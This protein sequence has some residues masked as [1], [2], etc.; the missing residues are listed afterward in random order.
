LTAACL[1]Y[2]VRALFSDSD[3]LLDV[4]EM[5]QTSPRC[6]FFKALSV[7]KNVYGAA[8]KK[9]DSGSPKCNSQLRRLINDAIPRL[10][11]DYSL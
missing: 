1:K 11:E 6:V 4:K 10:E 3:L 9:R 2:A 7:A 8:S 5:I